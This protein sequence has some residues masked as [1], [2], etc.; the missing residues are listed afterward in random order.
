MWNLN[1]VV[2]EDLHITLSDH[3]IP[4]EQLQGKTVVI[5]GATGLIGRTL[6]NTLLSYGQTVSN[7]P[8]VIAP[9]RNM[10]KAAA[11]FAPQLAECP[12]LTL[13]PWHARQPLSIEG[14]VDYILHC[15][16]Q[17]SSKGF[18]EQ[19][20]DTIATAYLGTEQV[21][22]LAS[23]KQAKG[24]V[25]LSSMEV[26]GTPQTDDLITESCIGSIDPLKVR[27][28]YP[29]SKRLCESLCVSYH[30][31]FGVPATIAR[32][33]QTFGPG[34]QQDDN[35]VFAEFARCAMEKRDIVL[36]TKGE[37]KRSY[38][39]TADAVRALLFILLSGTPGQAYNIANDET[40]CTIYEMA[41]MVANTLTNGEIQVRCE[42][43]DA[44]KLGY[45]PV[46]HMNLD[47]S[48]LKALGWIPHRDLTEMFQRMIRD[49]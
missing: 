10:E 20:V 49:F 37:T 36:H 15:A 13:L 7:P 11:F 1:A 26:Y 21:L 28:C 48:K 6:V 32:L 42:L 19:P 43:T 40:Y 2:Q 30:S 12:N 35:R 25:Y 34:V 31:Q 22:Q 18:I 9:V 8:R 47:V 24:F 23:Q 3:N 14:A 5:T 27:N 29:E 39:Y 41:C 38:V 45:A 44:E 4:W 33:T 17:T 16:S 46:L